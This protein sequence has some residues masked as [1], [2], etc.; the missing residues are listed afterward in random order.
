MERASH[1]YYVEEERPLSWALDSS[2]SLREAAIAGGGVGL[3]HTYLIGDAVAAG[4]LEVLMPSR[5]LTHGSI[6]LLFPHSQQL[7]QKT[8][9]LIDFLAAGSQGFLYG[10]G[11]FWR[12]RRVV[13]CFT[14]L[15][16]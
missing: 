11:T 2:F 15:C 1:Y 9:C 14:P 16:S 6:S 8:R 4:K 5:P 13:R 12:G 3:L 10:S 7:P